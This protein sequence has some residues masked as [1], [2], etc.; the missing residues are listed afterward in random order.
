[1][2]KVGDPASGR[3]VEDSGSSGYRVESKETVKIR[4]EGKTD[5][6]G[7]DWNHPAMLIAWLAW[8]Y[9]SSHRSSWGPEQYAAQEDNA[10]LKAEINSWK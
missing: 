8:G 3:K 5:K 10:K 6:V 7:N 1:M 2:S 9:K 4:R